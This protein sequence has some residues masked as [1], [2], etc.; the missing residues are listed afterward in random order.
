MA[1][2]NLAGQT[3]FKNGNCQLE[4][5][6]YDQ[7]YQIPQSQI[8][9]AVDDII[10]NCLK[11]NLP[12]SGH[13]Q[14]NAGPN[15]PWAVQIGSLT[16]TK[17]MKRA[18][19]E[20]AYLTEDS[21]PAAYR[22]Q[23]GEGLPKGGS[24]SE[25]NTKESSTTVETSVSVSADLWEVF[26]SS[27]GISVSQTQSYSSTFTETQPNTCDGEG[28]LYFQ[29]LFYQYHGG[30]SGGPSPVDIFVPELDSNGKIK[31]NYFVGCS[32]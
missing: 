19:F 22:T 14:I 18:M 3:L 5:Q 8:A 4:I 11:Q 28:Y 16:P 13:A 10:Q 1:D 7:G 31:G 17:K 2:F 27:V 12:A 30:F 32:G 6:F 29:P 26:T 24:W 21:Q 9:D 23:V 15:S 20:L 25:S